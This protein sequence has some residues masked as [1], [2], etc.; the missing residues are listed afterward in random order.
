MDAH[1]IITDPQVIAECREMIWRADTRQR[2]RDVG[3][4]PQDIERSVF[5]A[6]RI[7]QAGGV[8]V[9]VYGLGRIRRVGKP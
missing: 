7:A 2:A 8:M 1:R 4:A 9:A 5:L 3:V 6:W